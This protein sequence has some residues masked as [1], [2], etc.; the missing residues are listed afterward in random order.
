MRTIATYLIVQGFSTWNL[1]LSLSDAR[2]DGTYLYLTFMVL[3]FAYSIFMAA[4]VGVRQVVAVYLVTTCVNAL[5]D[6][7]WT[8]HGRFPEGAIVSASIG[9]AYLVPGLAGMLIR[10]LVYRRRKGCS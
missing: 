7:Y 6:I 4:G 10:K 2:R 1:W 8:G 5:L 3:V 9:L